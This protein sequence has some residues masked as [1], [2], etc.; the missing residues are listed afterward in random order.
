MSEDI[1]LRERHGNFVRIWDAD[2]R[3]GWVRMCD[4]ALAPFIKEVG[5]RL[6]VPH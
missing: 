2:S 3:E 1:V 5:L 6:G 4:E